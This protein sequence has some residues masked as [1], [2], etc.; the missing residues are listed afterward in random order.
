MRGLQGIAVLAVTLAPLLVQAG[1]AR[2]AGG[3]SPVSLGVSNVPFDSTDSCQPGWPCHVIGSATNPTTTVGPQG[4]KDWPDFPLCK[5]QA[6]GA[7]PGETR[8]G[9]LPRATDH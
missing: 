3:G 9:N 2:A 1:I 6:G 5:Q 4:C 8:S 7:K